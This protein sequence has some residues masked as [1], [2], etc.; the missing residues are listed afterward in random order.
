MQMIQLMPFIPVS[1]DAPLP[2]GKGLGRGEGAGLFEALLAGKEPIAVDALPKGPVPGAAP[3]R[4]AMIQQLETAVPETIGEAVALREAPADLDQWDLREAAQLS[5]PVEK[6]P[7][8]ARRHF[9]TAGEVATTGSDIEDVPF[10]PISADTHRA[11]EPV[12]IDGRTREAA[13]LREAAPAAAVSIL[14]GQS[15]GTQQGVEPTGADVLNDPKAQ[16]TIANQA[17]IPVMPEKTTKPRSES[18]NLMEQRFADLLGAGESSRA[19]FSAQEGLRPALLDPTLVVNAK[20]EGGTAAESGQQ[21]SPFGAAKGIPLT[22]GAPETPALVGGAASNL[23]SQTAATPQAKNEP[24]FQLPSGQ[25]VPE[26]RIV[27]QVVGRL[28]VRGGEEASSLTLK[29][30][31]K[32]LGEVKLNLIVEKDQVKAQLIAQNQQVQGVL[33]KNLPT[34]RSALEA[35][36]LKLDS[37]QVSVDSQNQNDRGFFQEHQRP[38]SPFRFTLRDE[39][40]EE[41]DETPLAS[42]A[43]A[44][45]RGINVRI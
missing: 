19:K 13:A 21:Q 28:T 44:A 11:V 26:S 12:P 40:S 8:D 1:G 38:A 22:Q 15:A 34:L 18:S 23:A 9:E 5:V 43:P 31:P 17:V 14:K 45:G 24:V 36:G 27:D 37:L 16:K 10:A 35:Q 41:V 39:G 20:S 4:T 32:E 7:D 33:E 2:E 6:R 3:D 25:T 29:L 30:Y 42:T